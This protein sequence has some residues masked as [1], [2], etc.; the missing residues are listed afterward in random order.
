MRYSTIADEKNLVR[1]DSAL[2][3]ASTGK[4]SNKL[5]GVYIERRGVPYH[6]QVC[7][8]SAERRC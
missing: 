1:D 8:L 2:A 7:Q 4:A 6:S 5:E 3:R